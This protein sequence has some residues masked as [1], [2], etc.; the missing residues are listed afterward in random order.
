ML[1][2]VLVMHRAGAGIAW[3]K[4]LQNFYYLW[5]LEFC[6]RLF[7]FDLELVVDIYVLWFLS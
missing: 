7:L 1:Q 3:E 4:L 5:I 6:K 2:V